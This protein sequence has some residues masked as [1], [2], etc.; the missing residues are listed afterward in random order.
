MRRV[1]MIIICILMVFSYTGCEKNIYQQGKES[2]VQDGSSSDFFMEVIEETICPT[3]LSIRIINNL[4]VGMLTGN[5][6][7]YDVELERDGKWYILETG[8]DRIETADAMSFIGETELKITWKYG[9]LK[10][11]NYRLVQYFVPDNNLE[12]T[13]DGIYLT[14]EF[15]IK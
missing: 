12:S 14:A 11:G 4:D 2:T 1:V 13:A 15:T 6:R 9:D 10:K 8:Q 7:T 5:E 3:G